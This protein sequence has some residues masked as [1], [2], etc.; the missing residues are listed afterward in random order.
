[1]NRLLVAALLGL[2]ISIA[3]WAT[4]GEVADKAAANKLFRQGS[5]LFGGGDYAAA[6]EKLRSAY[7]RY[8]S[9]KT[10]LHIGHTLRKLGR[11][12]EAIDA[13]ETYLDDPEADPSK[14]KSVRRTLHELDAVIARLRVELAE[15]GAKVSLDGKEIPAL[16]MGHDIRVEAGDHALVAERDGLPRV[17]QKIQL[18]ANER[19][20]VTVRFLSSPPSP[21]KVASVSPQ[22]TVG[23]VFMAAGGASLLAGAIATGLAVKKNREAKGHCLTTSICDQTGVD[24]GRSAKK[25]ALVATVTVSAGVSAFVS[26]LVLTLTAPRGP[27]PAPRPDS[28]ASPVAA[29][30]VSVTPGGGSFG[31]RGTW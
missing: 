15:P 8:P 25:T 21:P 12:I 20:T 3:P 6:L 9:A 26:G 16:Q 14:A 18:A 11:N 27:E 10:L 4:A 13:Y 31:L 17:V 22:R 29:I 23:V 7:K 1:M 28:R 19:R 5:Q 2:S 30:D 24:L